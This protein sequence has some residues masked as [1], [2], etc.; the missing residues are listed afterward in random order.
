MSGIVPIR[1]STSYGE[2]E[3]KMKIV[4]WLDNHL[5]EA[6]LVLCLTGIACVMMVQVIV[7]KVP[8]IR[9][10]E[11]AEEFC[12]FLWVM[13]V[14][15]SL[16]YTIR[17]S[18]ML[19]VSVLMDLFP[20][21]IRKIIRLGIDVVVCLAMALCAYHSLGVFGKVAVSNELSP[22]MLWPMTRVYVFM[23]IGFFLGT[24]RGIQMLVLHIRHF[25]EKAITTMEQTMADAKEEAMAGKRAEGGK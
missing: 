15:M 7:R 9:P 10:L 19:Q 2:M 6:F 16:P 5:E 3:E 20:E 12:R 25:G 22:A 14:F 1:F 18:S 17:K 11:W 13:S 4:R 21:K 23:V 8:F 24:F